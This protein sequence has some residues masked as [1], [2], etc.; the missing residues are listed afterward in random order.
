MPVAVVA[1]CQV[2]PWTAVTVFC[3]TLTVLSL[4]LGLTVVS[5]LRQVLLDLAALTVCVIVALTVVLWW[6]ALWWHFTVAALYSGC[7]SVAL[8][9]SHCVP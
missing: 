7:Q 5:C 8:T 4:L 2:S 3:C 6:L 9:V 1:L